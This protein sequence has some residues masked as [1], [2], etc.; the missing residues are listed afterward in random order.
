MPENNKKCGIRFLSAILRK[1]LC[2]WLL[3][4]MIHKDS[5][6]FVV[7]RR[8]ILVALPERQ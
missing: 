6:S 5:I 4:T 7:V 2:R 1:Q 8:D 3:I